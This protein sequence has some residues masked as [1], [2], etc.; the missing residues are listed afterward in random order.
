MKK[1]ELRTYVQYIRKNVFIH[2]VFL[3]LV[4]TVK[5][6]ATSQYNR[7]SMRKLHSVVI[8]D[9]TLRDGEQ[10]PGVSFSVEE[11][12]EIARMLDE[13]GIPQIEA[14]FLAVSEEE[15]RAVKA[16]TKEGLKADILVLSRSLISCL[17]Y[18]SPSPRD[19]G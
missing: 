13:L 15:R 8:Y 14:G 3:A 7:V 11:K 12:V 16:V 10:C 9:T 6:S 4:R 1:R 5:Y 17:L 19:R 18:T 2:S